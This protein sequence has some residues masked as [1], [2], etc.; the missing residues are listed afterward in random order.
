MGIWLGLAAGACTADTGGL[1]ALTAA[2]PGDPPDV[3]GGLVVT[4][5]VVDFGRS[6]PD[7]GVIVRSG[8]V[9]NEGTG[10]IELESVELVSDDGSV[11]TLR[12]PRLPRTL[13]PNQ[14]LE[15]SV[16]ATL[17]ENRSHEARVSLAAVVPGAGRILVER[18]V[19]A[20]ADNAPV[21]TDRFVQN[22]RRAA[23]V[24]FVI[25]DSASM[26]AEQDALGRNFVAFLEAANMGLADFQIGV[27]TTDLSPNGERGRLVPVRQPDDPEVRTAHIVTRSS[28]P[29]PVE[30]FRRNAQVGIEG[31]PIEQGLAAATLALTAPLTD[32]ESD[33]AGFLRPDAS[34]ALVF[35]SDENDGSEGP[36]SVYADIFASLKGYEPGRVTASAIVGPEAGCLGAGGRATP[37]TRYIELARVLRGRVESICTED[38]GD[39]LARLSGVA[40]GLEGRFVLSGQPSGDIAVSVNGS[41]RP[42]VNEAGETVWTIDSE[43]A[44]LSFGQQFTPPEGATIEISYPVACPPDDGRP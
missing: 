8:L 23:D 17:R 44:V 2:R 4:P 33:N 27:T 37:G 24:L 13:S 42:A 11:F 26:V 12:F 36:V 3:S 38:W 16:E 25:D 10:P 28:L 34:L 21:R 14:S 41:P 19:L 29:N 15:W 35:V 30:A 20:T 39:A 6:N 1:S 5:G 22:S 7:C 32:E 43:V 18:R 31:A 9:R 40:F